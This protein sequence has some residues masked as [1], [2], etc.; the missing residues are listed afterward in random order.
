[1][2]INLEKVKNLKDWREQLIVGQFTREN[3]DGVCFVCDIN[4]EGLEQI[5]VSD[6][7]GAMVAVMESYVNMVPES[8][9]IQFEK[10]VTDR[11]L[12]MIETRHEHIINTFE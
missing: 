10:E 5:Y 1:M 7:I 6:A 2:E 8:Q 3:L 12:E 11:L 4:T 9:Q